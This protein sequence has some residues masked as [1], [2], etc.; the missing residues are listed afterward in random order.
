MKSSLSM[1]KYFDGVESETT[2]PVELSMVE[3]TGNVKNI[4]LKLKSSSTSGHPISSPVKAA[5][6]KR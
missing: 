3:R 1:K 4:F 2:L 6:R 5:V